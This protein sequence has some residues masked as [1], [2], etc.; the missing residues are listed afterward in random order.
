MSTDVDVEATRPMATMMNAVKA[1]T[2]SN[3]AQNSNSPKAL[4][5]MRL[6]D[7]RIIKATSEGTHIGRLGHQ[8]CR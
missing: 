5:L 1:T 2:L 6:T 4:T 3:A 8:N 7:T